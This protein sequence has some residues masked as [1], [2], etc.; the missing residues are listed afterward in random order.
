MNLEIPYLKYE[1]I[2]SVANKFLNDHWPSG[3][4]PIPIEEIVE[5][6]LRLRIAPFPELFREIK[7]N[8][9]LTADRSTIFVDEIQYNTY[10]EKYRFSIAHEVG[11]Y[12]LHSEYYEHLPFSDIDTYKAWRLNADPEMVY[13]FEVQGNLFA[14]L[15]LMP[16]PQLVRVCEQVV[17]NHAD[18]LKGVGKDVW[19]YL[20]KDVAVEFEVS[21][22]SASI[23]IEHEDIPAIVSLPM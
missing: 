11:H 10:A 21:P 19:P 15:I 3:E 1:E 12:V 7:L 2:K 9:F 20:A 17:K 14:E 8:A 6:S 22:L 23:R 16:S 5:L 13:R 18:H 4:I